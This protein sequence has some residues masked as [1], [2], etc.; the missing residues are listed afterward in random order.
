MIRGLHPWP[1]AF[2]FL[3][4]R[5]FIVRRSRWSGE[6]SAEAPGTVI[7]A[8]G[9][10]LAVATGSGVLEITEIQSEGKRPMSAREFLAG[11]PLSG[12]ERFGPL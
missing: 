8:A 10:R 4:P 3:G 6:P 12:G 7:E 1:H 9:D 2:T 5:R 11:H